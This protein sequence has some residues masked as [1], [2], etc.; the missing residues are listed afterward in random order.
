MGT[1]WKQNENKNDI[2]LKRNE[3]GTKWKQN[4]MKS[5]RKNKSDTVSLMS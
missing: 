2:K 3:M 5:I 4:E 1:K